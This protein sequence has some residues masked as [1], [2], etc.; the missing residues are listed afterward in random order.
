MGNVSAFAA[1]LEADNITLGELDIAY[2]R[3]SETNN[4]DTIKRIE[5]PVLIIL[6]KE[7]RILDYRNGEAF[8]EAIPGARL[9]ILEGIGHAPM[10]E[11]PEE[12]ARLFFEFAKTLTSK[13]G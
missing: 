11:A 9:E 5:D 13:A 1:G 10:I 4:G 3:N 7:D 12:S 6:G 8:L 2:L